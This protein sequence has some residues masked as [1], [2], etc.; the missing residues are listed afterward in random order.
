MYNMHVWVYLHFF[1]SIS[2]ISN[3]V[4]M[5]RCFSSSVFVLFLFIYFCFII[6]ER[7]KLTVSNFLVQ[8][9]FYFSY[10]PSI[11]LVDALW[12]FF[13][14]FWFKNLKFYM[15]ISINN[16]SIT[17]FNNLLMNIKKQRL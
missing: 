17:L 12:F 15:P 9:I 14:F 6:N 1:K 5:S 16:M 11:S 10:F 4:I 3:M 2:F 7:T 8:S 13:V